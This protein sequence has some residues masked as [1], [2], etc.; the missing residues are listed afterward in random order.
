MPIEQTNP[1]GL[2]NTSSEH[3]EIVVEHSPSNGTIGS[4][5]APDERLLVP[6]PEGI[7][8]KLAM[9]LWGDPETVSSYRALEARY[10]TMT[11]GHLEDI[12]RP[13]TATC[14]EM[15]EVY[16]RLRNQLVAKL[17]AEELVATGY[18]SRDGILG[19][20]IEIPA[21]RWP[22]FELN[23]EMSFAILHGIRITEILVSEAVERPAIDRRPNSFS[24]AVVEEWY[25]DRV[26]KL[27]AAGEKSTQAEDERAARDK[28]GSKGSSREFVRKL[29]REHAPEA[30][31]KRGRKPSP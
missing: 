28:F 15:F 10:D 30:W 31:S 17:T 13:M 18:D 11:M 9:F 14:V 8:L 27:E 19:K 6:D 3:L 24:K 29:R 1:S 25:V 16:E 21:E 23:C 26:R 5:K 22:A 12:P 20:R 2:M 4:V 7:P